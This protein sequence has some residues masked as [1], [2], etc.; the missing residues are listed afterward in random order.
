MNKA[1]EIMEEFTIPGTEV[2]LEK[3]DKVKII[4]ESKKSDQAEEIVN[5]YGIKNAW[6][7]LIRWI[8]EV[9]FQEYYEY[10]MRLYKAYGYNE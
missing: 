3:G 9:D 7:A 10:T 6:D 5:I 1:I 8:P 4:Q 2:I